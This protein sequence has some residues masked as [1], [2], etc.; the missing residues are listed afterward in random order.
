MLPKKALQNHKE[1][2]GPT[3]FL[4]SQR[5]QVENSQGVNKMGTK[6][7]RRCESQKCSSKQKQAPRAHTT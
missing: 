5:M 7:V 4:K 1:K 3:K 6:C 2:A